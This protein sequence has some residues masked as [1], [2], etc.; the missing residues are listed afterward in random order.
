M[1]ERLH[2]QANAMCSSARSGTFPVGHAPEIGQ[3]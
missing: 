1:A 3:A 2:E